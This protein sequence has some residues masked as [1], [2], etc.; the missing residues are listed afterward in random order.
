LGSRGKGS[1]KQEKEMVMKVTYDRANLDSV[2]RAALRLKATNDMFVYATAGGYG[3]YK[4][5]PIGIEQGYYKVHN[6]GQ[7]ARMVNLV[8]P[9][10]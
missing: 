2:I 9:R 10:G 3:I 4:T 7:V 1:K 6:D 5:P 8:G